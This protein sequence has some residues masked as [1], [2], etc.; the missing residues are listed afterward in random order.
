MLCHGS[1]VGQQVG[2]ASLSGNSIAPSDGISS[3]R[4]RGQSERVVLRTCLD[5][6]STRPRTGQNGWPESGRI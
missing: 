2:L 3:A 1:D 6:Q 4:G 5:A